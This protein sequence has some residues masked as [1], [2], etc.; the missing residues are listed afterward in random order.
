MRTINIFKQLLLLCLLFVGTA[1]VN[2]VAYQWSKVTNLSDVQTGDIV[3]IVDESLGIALPN[4]GG[5]FQGV[6]VTVSD[7]LTTSTVSDEIKWTLTKNGDSFKFERSD[8][9]LLYG[10]AAAG[11][12]RLVMNSGNYTTNTFY[13]DDYNSGG[14]L[15]Y[16]SEATG[17]PLY[18][19]W[20]DQKAQVTG[21]IFDAATITL[22]KIVE[23]P[24]TVKWKL[25]DDDKVTL[26]DGDVVV[27]ADVATGLAMS[28]D[29]DTKD[30]DAVAVELNYDK[31]RLIGEVPEKVQWTYTAAS[32]G[33]QF[34]AGEDKFLYA[35]S[36]GLKVGSGSDKVFDMYTSNGID[37]L[38]IAIGEKDYLAGVEES[39]FSNSWKLKELKDEQPDQTVAETRIAIFKKVDDTQ[40][41]LTLSFPS[42]N[43][44]VNT[45]HNLTSPNTVYITFEPAEASDDV[46]A[47][48]I[49]YSSSKP[50]VLYPFKEGDSNYNVDP[51]GDRLNLL[52]SGTT[53]F[54][55]R[56]QETDEYDKAVTYCTIRYNN[57][58]EDFTGAKGTKSNPLTVS[59]AIRLAKGETVEGVT[60]EEDRCYF[61]KGKVNKVNSGMLAMFGDMGL[62]EM[63]GD[64][65]DMDERM[66][67]M[68]DF[69][70]SEMGDMMGGMDFASM[71]PGFGSSDGLTYYISDDGT[72]D[73]RM[74]VTNGHGLVQKTEGSNAVSFEELDD[75]SPG[76]DVLVYGPLVLSEDDNMFASLFG[77]SGG[78]GGIGQQDTSDYEWAPTS[79][80]DL[81]SDDVVLLVDKNKKLA[82]STDVKGTS[83]KINKDK[84]ADNVATSI[85]WTLTKND[86]GTLTFTTD[87]TPL[88]VTRNLNLIVGQGQSSGFT[89]NNGYLGIEYSSSIGRY[90]IKWQEADGSYSAIFEN[91]NTAS[92]NIEADFTFYKR[93]EKTEEDN[94]TVKVD[95]L[96]YLHELTKTLVVQDQHMYVDYTKSLATDESFFYTLNQTPEGSIQPAQVKTSD[97]EIAKWVKIDE[98]NAN[99]DSLF[100]AVK[101]GTAKITVK[102]KVIV[103]P[104][105]GDE[106]EKSYTMKR[107]FKLE[108]RPR[109]KEP[110]GK[111]VG[112]YVLVESADELVDGTR[113]L[114]VGT[115]TT[116]DDDNQT[117]TSNYTLSTNNSMMGGGKSGNTIDNDKITTNDAGKERILYDDVPDGT[118]EII[119]EKDG[120]YWYLNVGKDENGEKLYLYSSLKAKEEG[121]EEGDESTSGFD[122][123]EMMEMFMPSSGLKVA[124]RAA[125]TSSEGV[126]SCRAVI[127]IDNKIA[128]IKFITV[129]DTEKST[130]VLT[131]AFDLGSMMNMF[132]GDE[133]ENNDDPN[134]EEEA[135]SGMNFDFFMASFNT[136]K[137]DEIDGEKAILPRIFGF[138]QYD[139]YPVNIGTAEWMTIVSD[140]DVTPQDGVTAYVV[141]DVRLDQSQPKAILKKVECLKGGEPYLLHSTTGEYK[142]TRTSDV[143]TPEVNLLLVS[144]QNT[145]GVSGNTSVYVL[146]NKNKGVG[147]YK[148]TG[149]KLGA[150]RVYLPVEA[151]VAG[152]DE[153]CSF[154][155]EVDE[156]TAIREIDSTNPN[157]GIYYDLQGRR[158]L[159]P[160]KGV[161]IMDGK[162]QVVK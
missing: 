98:T 151:S 58:W 62:D 76:D 91:I 93:V 26:T 156:T 38:H 3:V 128:T 28:N 32:G 41:V 114:I 85:Q 96:N 135:S 77:G 110:E 95:E 80:D 37:Y 136:K 9:K 127:S 124:T 87:N 56:I 115:R 49:E 153:Y 158:V 24:T 67:D 125:A 14:K 31:D 17:R 47:R 78:I 39:M 29:K 16:E 155:E 83:V 72:K 112:E 7:N 113:L 42:E 45:A 101:P 144:D 122:M 150:G 159:K 68:D 154:L 97:E 102:I 108:V 15:N 50:S 33:F 89:Y 141:T 137:S 149:G 20:V 73:N 142:M 74:K 129:P 157:V 44:E 81:N 126:D 53:H 107:K 119:L 8:G 111:N 19:Y 70:M 120:E 13:F 4:T 59:E 1:N 118:Q 147:F 88:S 130:I 46:S 63:M 134:Q 139:E 11:S 106:K 5:D 65:M 148:W 138:V 123:D 52:N 145:E 55:A 75:L 143:E 60:Y 12:E 57:T 160:T 27:I 146:A 117:K 94:R 54:I 161:Y 40:K 6:A 162:K 105:N 18:V 92:D 90:I 100:T 86:D 51:H 23:V 131:S 30:P 104:A 2:A 21:S 140:F 116:T 43:Y 35:D 133:E 48:D 69:D 82:L 79:L 103:V 132:G 84:I 109:D 22:Y 25:V 152:A 99:S 61:I 36:K 34:A 71:I 66:G 64:D 121:D 10:D